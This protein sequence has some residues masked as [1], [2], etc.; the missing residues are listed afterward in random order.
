V[1]TPAVT[2][3]ASDTRSTPEKALSEK[4]ELKLKS[5]PAESKFGSPVWS[6]NGVFTYSARGSSVWRSARPNSVVSRSN[7]S[8]ASTLKLGITR[9][10]GAA[11]G[12][13]LVQCGSWPG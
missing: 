1:V 5:L 8:P 12:Q 10:A 2:W 13:R 4:I 3:C 6:R 7:S 11:V 9:E